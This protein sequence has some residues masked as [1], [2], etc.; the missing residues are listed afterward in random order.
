MDNYIFRNREALLLAIANDKETPILDIYGES[1]I[2][3]TRLLDEAMKIIT[4]QTPR[5]LILNVDLSTIATI[6]NVDLKKEKL[7]ELL[8]TH[9]QGAIGQIWTKKYNQAVGQIV[10]DLLVGPRPVYIV[11]DTTEKIQEDSVFWA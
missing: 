8:V 7:L 10:A 5:A 3:K 6:D 9:L 11:F 4:Q 2:G 1:G